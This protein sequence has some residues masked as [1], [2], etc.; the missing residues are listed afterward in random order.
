PDGTPAAHRPRSR[1]S[2]AGGANR[3]S[4]GRASEGRDREMVATDQSGQHQGGVNPTWILS[5]ATHVL[6]IGYQADSS[7]SGWNKVASSPSST[8][9]LARPRFMMPMDASPV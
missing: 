7:I 3:R 6:P 5:S 9:S 8:H 1:N 4:A 2:A